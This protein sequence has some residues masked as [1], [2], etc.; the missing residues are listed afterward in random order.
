MQASDK[1]QAALPEAFYVQEERRT[2]PPLAIYM[3]RELSTQALLRNNEVGFQAWT[4]APF[5][6]GLLSAMQHMMVKE[7]V[8]PRCSSESVNQVKSLV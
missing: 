2:D 1:V 3:N 7:V 5:L 4:C 8:Y 6:I